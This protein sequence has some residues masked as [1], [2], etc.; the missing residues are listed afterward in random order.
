VILVAGD[1]TKDI[2]QMPDTDDNSRQGRLLSG[3]YLNT[4][5]QIICRTTPGKMAPATVMR[6]PVAK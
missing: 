5:Q 2:S 3:E 4:L 6:T 1:P